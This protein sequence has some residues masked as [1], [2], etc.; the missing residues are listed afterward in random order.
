MKLLNRHP[1][2]TFAVFLLTAG[3]PSIASAGS[4]FVTAD[5]FGSQWPLTVRSGTLMCTPTG[6]GLGLLWFTP[7]DGRYTGQRF[8][9]NGLAVARQQTPQIELIWRADESIVRTSRRFGIRFGPNNPMP[10]MRMTP[11]TER[12]LSLCSQ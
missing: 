6:G 9:L 1:I 12:G 10:R 8:A 11:L 5:E 3:R 7:A 4:V 2:L